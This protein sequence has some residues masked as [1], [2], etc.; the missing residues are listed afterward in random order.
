MLDQILDSR[1]KAH[2]AVALLLTFT[3]LPAQAKR[4][5]T[6]LMK[7]GDRLTGEVK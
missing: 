1:T 2:F 3:I 7:N 4:K 6:V 5:D